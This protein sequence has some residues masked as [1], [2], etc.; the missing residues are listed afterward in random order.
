MKKFI[1]IASTAAL[2]SAF[3]MPSMAAKKTPEEVCKA[4]AE[5]KKIAADKM[6]EFVQKC[7]EKRTKARHAVKAKEPAATP[8]PEAQP[9]K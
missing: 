3:T 9:A 5:K 1:V 8:A 4:R 7:V 2:L 6:D